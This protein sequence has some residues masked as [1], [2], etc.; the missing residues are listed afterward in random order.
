MSTE[1]QAAGEI[2]E[3]SQVKRSDSGC[4]RELVEKII[5]K[6]SEQKQLEEEEQR[7][8]KTQQ[9]NRKNTSSSHRSSTL[10]YQESYGLGKP[11]RKVD[12]PASVR[13]K[14]IKSKWEQ[15]VD[16]TQGT[17]QRSP[18]KI[19]VSERDVKTARTNEEQKDCDIQ[20]TKKEKIVR[21]VSIESPPGF[22][23][24]TRRS[25]STIPLKQKIP[26]LK[27]NI[28]ERLKKDNNIDDATNSKKVSLNVPFDYE[29]D[30]RRSSGTIKVRNSTKVIPKIVADDSKPNTITDDAE[31]IEKKVKKHKTDPANIKT[32]LQFKEDT[33]LIG[34]GDE[35]EKSQRKVSIEAP[36]GFDKDTRRSRKTIPVMK[37]SDQKGYLNPSFTQKNNNTEIPI[38]KVSIES[39]PGFDKDTRRSSE[40]IPVMKIPELKR[41]INQYLS[42]SSDER[43]KIDNSMDSNTTKTKKVCLNTP[44]V[45]DKDTRRSSG[46]MKVRNRKNTSDGL[47]E[48]NK[49]AAPRRRKLSDVVEATRWKEVA[50][51][52][53]QNSKYEV[54]VMKDDGA[55]D[56]ENVTKSAVVKN[57]NETDNKECHMTEQ[58]FESKENEVDGSVPLKLSENTQNDSI[59][60]ENGNAI[61]EKNIIAEQGVDYQNYEGIDLSQKDIPCV[62]DSHYDDKENASYTEEL[63]G[64]EIYEKQKTISEV[65]EVEADDSNCNS[66]LKV[67]L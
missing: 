41:D 37:N 24:D 10:K 34:K 67:R 7:L 21:K 9:N 11:K 58:L 65:C 36:P 62:N 8:R 5:M 61:N 52:A 43:I 14:D 47:A 22:D 44:F 33:L 1:Q 53:I 66:M 27:W 50:A 3:K 32:K 46:T 29:K 49:D 51:A 26:E 28:D 54:V 16:E 12:V 38:R 40:T 63:S 20:D 64:R 48:E 2:S 18:S 6:T 17:Q 4:V 13:V 35:K 60:N 19:P 15:L 59:A 45:Y 30:T 23:K 39:P 55:S 42:P 25:S 57:N 56:M 31:K